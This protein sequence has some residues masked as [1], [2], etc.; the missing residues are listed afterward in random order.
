VGGW[1][2]AE[3]SLSLSFVRSP[4][5]FG[6][7]C[8]V[9]LSTHHQVSW[10]FQQ[11]P[12]RVHCRKYSLYMAKECAV[13]D[14][15]IQFHALLP[16]S[17]FLLPSFFAASVASFVRWSLAVLCCA[18]LCCAVC[19][20][21]ASLDSADNEDDDAPTNNLVRVRS[22]AVGG[23]LA[24]LVRLSDHDCEKYLQLVFC[25]VP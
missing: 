2:E 19:V 16:P 15:F 6:L 4:S 13:S 25:G 17:F 24:C 22:C 7:L 10:K 3:L 5:F 11:H 14:N 23:V 9:F 21:C 18:V 1:W 20:R 8:T 12:Y